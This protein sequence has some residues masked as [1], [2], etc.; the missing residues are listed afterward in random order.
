MRLTKFVLLAVSIIGIYS[1][2]A[3]IAHAQT[4]PIIVFGP[5]Q[6]DKPKGKPVTYTDTFQTISSS[7]THTIWVQNGKDGLNE[8]KHLSIALN[9]VEVINFKD[10][11]AHNPITKPITVQPDNTLTVTLNGKEGNFVTVKILCEGCSVAPEV[12][13]VFPEDG[14]TIN[15]SS[16]LVKGTI[17]TR[18]HEVGIVVNG[19]LAELSGDTFA[20]N[21]VP[22][23]IGEN[24]IT[25]AATDA[26]GNTSKDTITVHT[27]EYHNLVNINVDKTSGLS[28]MT[29]KFSID[30]QISNQITKYEIDFEGD[31][32][33]D[34][35]IGDTENVSFTYNQV[36][37]YYPTI[38][39]TDDQGN[40]YTDTIA[41]NVLSLPEMDTLLQAKWEDL[42][43]ALINEDTEEA[44]KLFHKDSRA[45]YREQ[46]SALSPILNTIGNGL[47][48]LRLVSIEDNRAEYEIIVIRDSVTYSYFL[49]F[50][51]DQDGLWKI[52]RF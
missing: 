19:V 29:V 23:D 52:E 31:G 28:P 40:Q 38:M 34:H 1:I 2:T 27:N 46:F 16:T 14:S 50:E 15:T 30:T 37:L 41:V 9:G 22:L 44:L 11:R 51:R 4:E 24:T 13:I 5:K 33:I 47:G 45:V 6:Y 12:H 3:N 48:Y 17:D 35:T 8:V 25:A 43:T 20:A 7:G 42:R 26:E 49:L 10:L 21:D 39:V 32:I 18:I 36:G